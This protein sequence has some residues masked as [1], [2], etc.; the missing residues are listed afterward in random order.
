MRRTVVGAERVSVMDEHAAPVSPGLFC[1]MALTTVAQPFVGLSSAM[2]TF[3]ANGHFS[4]TKARDNEVVPMR[5]AGTRDKVVRY[6]PALL[7]L[8]SSEALNA[9]FC[10]AFGAIVPSGD[11]YPEMLQR[12]FSG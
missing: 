8:P 1:S 3:T 11:G 5:V 4:F 9:A 7:S 10:P 2:P 6:A 12:V